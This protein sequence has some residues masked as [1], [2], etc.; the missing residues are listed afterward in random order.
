MPGVGMVNEALFGISRRR[1]LPYFAGTSFLTWLDGHR[2]QGDKETRRQGDEQPIVS[3]SLP[4]SQ[5]VVLFPDTFA[6]YNEPQ[7]AVAATFLLE[8]LGYRVIVPSRPVCCGRPL[9]SK[10]LLPAAKRLAQQQL[11]WLAPYAEHGLPIIGLEPSCLLTFRDEYPDLIDD[12]RTRALAEHSLLL[13][14]FLAR[15]LERG[16]LRH[17]QFAPIFSTGQPAL[18]HGHC[19]QKALA[20]TAPTKLLLGVAGFV[21]HEVDSG[22]CGMAGSFGYEQEHYELS[23]KIGERVLLPTVRAAAP[24]TTVVAMGTSCRQ[25]IQHSTGRSARHLAEVLWE[26]VNNEQ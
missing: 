17:E 20:S 1:S 25:Q 22:C 14:E 5:S 16:A 13:D 15:E 2:R 4:L 11:D 24:D 19:H 10:G 8:T 26:A 9:L 12:R 6:L 21:P 7:I 18:V 3:P 23:L